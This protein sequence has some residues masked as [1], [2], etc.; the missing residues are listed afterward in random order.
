VRSFSVRSF[1]VRLFSARSF[2]ARLFSVRSFSI[3]LFSARLFLLFSAR[4]QA[5][6]INAGIAITLTGVITIYPA[7]I[8]VRFFG[9]D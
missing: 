5:A 2:L 9:F 1:S 7:G 4:R 8:S 3:K 6:C